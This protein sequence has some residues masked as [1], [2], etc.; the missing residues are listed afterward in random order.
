MVGNEIPSTAKRLPNGMDFGSSPDPTCEV[1]L[2]LDGIDL[3]MDEIFCENNLLPEKLKGAER[4]SIVDRKDQ[5]VMKEVKSIIPI[6]KFVRDDE[7]Y[8]GYDKEKYKGIDLTP[9][10]ILIKKEIARIKSWQV[11]GDS[12]GKTELVD[13]DKHGYNV[14]GVKKPHNGLMIGVKRLQSYNLKVTARSKN[15]KSDLEKWMRK[16][17]HNGKIIPEPDGHEPDTLA[18]SRYVMLAKSVW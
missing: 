4:L 8:L 14:R 11:I 6:D 9:D 15:I 5:I 13:L 10:D 18:A 17:D 16:I 7:F 2:Y 12:S 3:Y 1:A